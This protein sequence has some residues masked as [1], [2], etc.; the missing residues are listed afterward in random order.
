MR[1]W[2][3]AM[4]VA[5]ALLLASTS[6]IAQE[7]GVSGSIERLATST[8]AEK[9]KY[10]MEALDEMRANLRKM[11]AI[12]ERAPECVTERLPLLRSL[13]EVSQIAQ[14][15]MDRWI[16]EGNSTRADSEFR[17]IAIALSEA[18]TLLAEAERCN[19][20]Q[21]SAGDEVIREVNYEGAVTTGDETLE[22]DEFTFDVGQDP[23]QSSPF[24]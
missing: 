3:Y 5:A 6:G 1:S 22:V 21:V 7:T 17:K 2:F 14:T 11:E 24:M 10:A 18:R 12:E 4:P 23:P 15:N 16:A 9:Q 8:P 19:S 20:G 13:V